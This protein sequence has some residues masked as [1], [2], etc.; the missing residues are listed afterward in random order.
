MLPVNEE[1]NTTPSSEE[2]SGCRSR[3]SR[4]FGKC[5]FQAAAAWSGR[6]LPAVAGELRMLKY[7][8]RLVICF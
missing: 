1:I 2:I 8:S 5:T 7:G 4:T 6:E 3:R